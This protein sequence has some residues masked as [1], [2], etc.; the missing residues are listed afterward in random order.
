M[1]GSKKIFVTLFVPNMT[2]K[3]AECCVWKVE[4]QSNVYIQYRMKKV[5][6]IGHN[7]YVPWTLDTITHHFGYIWACSHE[8]PLDCLS[9]YGGSK[10]SLV[11]AKFLQNF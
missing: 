9:K 10:M 11:V 6:L 2:S 4:K 8:F 7:R 5:Y 3:Y 1:L